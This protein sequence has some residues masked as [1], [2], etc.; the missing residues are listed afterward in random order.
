MTHSGR[1]GV[2]VIMLAIFA[3]MVA[4]ATG[5]PPD[6]RFLPFVI[7]IPGTALC[8]IQL[9]IDILAA[10]REPGHRLEADERARLRAAVVLF[11]WLALFMIAILLLGFL[12]AMPLLL[13]AFLRLN[14]RESVMLSAVLA[15]GG[16]AGMWLLFDVMLRLP[17]HE[18]FL[19]EWLAG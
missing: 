7:G 6:S 1:I 15:L 11:G 19:L 12:Y 16:M 10:R 3:T 14:Q 2:S 9:V 4:M 18:G 17:L 5:Y 13:F 8:A